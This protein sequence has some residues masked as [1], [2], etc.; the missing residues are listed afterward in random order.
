M[1]SKIIVKLKDSLKKLNKEQ[2][3]MAACLMLSVVVSVFAPDVFFASS[4][5]KAEF[6]GKFE[7]FETLFTDLVS[8][9]GTIYTLWAIAEWGLAWHESNGTM[10]GQSFKRIMGGLVVIL[11]PQILAIL[12]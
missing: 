10:G 1:K 2:V 4:S 9:L 6:M 3:F 11:A 12:A 5:A 8:I 7:S